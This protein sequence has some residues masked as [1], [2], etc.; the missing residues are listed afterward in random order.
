MKF[1]LILLAVSMAANFYLAYQV[2]NIQGRYQSIASRSRTY[3]DVINVAKA[4]ENVCFEVK[5]LCNNK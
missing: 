4:M 5:K 3:I 1:P 2:S